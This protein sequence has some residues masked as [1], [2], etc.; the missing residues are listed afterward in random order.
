MFQIG[1]CCRVRSQ[2]RLSRG[3]D[4]NAEFWRM[5]RRFL[6]RGGGGKQ[7]ENERVDNNNPLNLKVKSI[8]FLH[9]HI[10]MS[11]IELCLKMF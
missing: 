8:I 2:R 4:I 5:S 11:L 10:Q 6:S 9:Y 1:G 3:T 7:K